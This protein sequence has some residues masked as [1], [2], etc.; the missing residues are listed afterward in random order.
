MAEVQPLI[1]GKA[2]SFVSAVLEWYGQT[3]LFTEL[4]YKEAQAKTNNYENS[5]YAT[6]RTYGKVEQTVSVTLS[7]AQ[8]IILQAAAPQNGALHSIPPSPLRVTY[9]DT[10]E[11]SVTDVI[12]MFEF[13]EDG[14]EGSVDD[15]FLTTTYECICSYISYNV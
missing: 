4:N 14:V 12:H 1:N 9:G 6:S 7:K 11:E 10:G 13:K 3:I 8:V 5:K 15:D 2:R